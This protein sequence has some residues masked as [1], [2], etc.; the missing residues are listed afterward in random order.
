VLRGARISR[1][2]A[3]GLVIGR[4][5]NAARNVASLLGGSAPETVN[6]CGGEGSGREHIPGSRAL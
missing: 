2:E 3:C 6:A 5:L 1:R 4:D